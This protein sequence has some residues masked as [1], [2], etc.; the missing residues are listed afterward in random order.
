VEK[1]VSVKLVLLHLTDVSLLYSHRM[2]GTA[3]SR[4]ALSGADNATT[5]LCQ[6][7]VIYLTMRYDVCGNLASFSCRRLSRRI[8]R[9]SNLMFAVLVGNC[10]RNR[11]DACFWVPPSQAANRQMA[12]GGFQERETSSKPSRVTSPPAFQ[13]VTSTWKPLCVCSED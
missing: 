4:T 8:L 3:P 2:F 11:S 6:A 12:N 13:N 10:S 7:H 1:S 5:V 9:R